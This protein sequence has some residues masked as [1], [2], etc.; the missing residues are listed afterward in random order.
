MKRLLIQTQ[1][2]NYDTKGNFIL[3]CDSGW[4]MVMGRVREMLKLNP[5]LQIDVMG[6]RVFG[7]YNG[8]SS[9]ITPPHLV[10]PDMEWHYLYSYNDPTIEDRGRLNYI[11]HEIM[12]NA[13]ATRY[14]FHFESLSLIL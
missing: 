14:D 3:E 4:Q 1:L 9:V 7:M 13:L 11:Q 2:S 5:D 10:N 12:S 8:D 6:P